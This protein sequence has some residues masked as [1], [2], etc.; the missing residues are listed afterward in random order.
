MRECQE[1]R[2]AVLLWLWSCC[3]R[4]CCRTCGVECDC[5]LPWAI[6]LMDCWEHALF[7]FTET[8][9]GDSF[10]SLTRWFR[11]NHTMPSYRR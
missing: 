7:Y 8:V 4:G 1:W 9:N 5:V 6:L 10:G 3:A 11:V 2:V